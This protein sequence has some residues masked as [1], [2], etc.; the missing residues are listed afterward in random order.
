MDQDA[1]LDLLLGHWHNLKQAQMYPSSF[2]YIHYWWYVDEDDTLRSKQWYD[3]NGEIYRQR[4]HS[5]ISNPNNITLKTWIDDEE[6]PDLVFT[7]SEHGYQGSTL[8]GAVNGKGN[9]VESKIL[10]TKETFDTDDKGWNDQ[11]KMIWGTNRGP[12]Q[13]IRCSKSIPTTVSSPR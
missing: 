3:W 1:F 9:K 12:F 10:L 8:P 5:L 13:F 2:A 11:G 6:M 4:R 7:E